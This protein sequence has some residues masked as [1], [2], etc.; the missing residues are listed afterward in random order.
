MAFHKL[1]ECPPSKKF[2]LHNLGE[3]VNQWELQKPSCTPR[4]VDPKQ[5][6]ATLVVG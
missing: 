2:G 4:V 3:G 6:A 1:E 5:N